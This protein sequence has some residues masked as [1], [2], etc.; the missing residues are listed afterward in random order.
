MGIALK[1]CLFY[2]QNKF[3]EKICKRILRNFENYRK[4]QNANY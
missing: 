3:E 1:F 2:C 4:L